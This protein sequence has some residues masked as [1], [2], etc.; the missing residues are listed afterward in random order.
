MRMTILTMVTTE[1]IVL[2][3]KTTQCVDEN[4]CDK[5]TNNVVDELAVTGI[6]LANIDL[7]T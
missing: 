2:E 1:E 6:I 7:M 5:W 3:Q 4:S